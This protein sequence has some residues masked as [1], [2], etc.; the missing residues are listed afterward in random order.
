MIL[1]F[2]KF[3]F[4]LLLL[5]YNIYILYFLMLSDN[6]LSWIRTK[7]IIRGQTFGWPNAIKWSAKST[8]ARTRPW[9]RAITFWYAINSRKHFSLNRSFCPHNILLPEIDCRLLNLDLEPDTDQYPDQL[10]EFDTDQGIPKD[11]DHDQDNIPDP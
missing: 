3:T 7:A 8:C 9:L 4:L 5:T 11:I 10:L 6:S 1:S 2:F